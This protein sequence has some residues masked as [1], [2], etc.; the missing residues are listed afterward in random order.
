MVP[1]KW[2]CRPPAAK[3]AERSERQRRCDASVSVE[4]RIEHLYSALRIL[5]LLLLLLLRVPRVAE[6]QEPA[7]HGGCSLLPQRGRRHRTLPTTVGL[8]VGPHAATAKVEA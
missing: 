1:A 5:M 6:R 4:S 3:V 8:Q 2:Q 7:G